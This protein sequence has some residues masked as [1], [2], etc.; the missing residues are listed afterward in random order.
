MMNG[1][2]LDVDGL[3]AELRDGSDHRHRKFVAEGA[4]EGRPV[5]S[6]E[7]GSRRLLEGGVDSRDSRSFSEASQA[8]AQVAWAGCWS[9][10]SL[11][12][13]GL[14]HSLIFDHG[15]NSCKNNRN[16]CMRQIIIAE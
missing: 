11:E 1:T 5:I 14:H 4:R 3:D 9:G 10:M 15:P 6:R 13:F 12:G 16:I 8:V 2:H 7:G